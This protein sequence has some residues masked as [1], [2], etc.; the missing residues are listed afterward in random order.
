[1]RVIR[2][3]SR[4]SAP[5]AI[6]HLKLGS[7][8]ELPGTWI[9]TGF[10]LIARPDFQNQKPFFLEIN[11]TLEDLEFQLI[12]GG[13][14]NRGSEQLDINLHG[15]HYLQ[16]IA[17]CVTHGALH[18]ET[19]MW[20]NIPETT[21]PKAPPTVVRQSTIAHGDSLLAQTTFITDVAGGP[22]INPVDSFPFTDPTIPDLN[23]PANNIITNPLYVGPY[24]NTALPEG[25]LPPRLDPQATIRNPTLALLAAIKGQNITDTAVIQV[26]TAAVQGS[27][28][29]LNIPFVVRNANALRMDAILW[30]ETVQPSDGDPF[31]QLQYVQRVILDFPPKPNAPIIHWPHISVAT[32]VKQ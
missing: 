3:A 28:G 23:T 15:L 22:V 4:A 17:D 20:I 8:R 21:D 16:K 18:I 2:P 31:L 25:C 6:D 1:M 29:I 14:P 13:I 32:L 5:F 19:G 26:S 11:G 10:K 24:L 9:G 30:I 27:T 12:G 7:L